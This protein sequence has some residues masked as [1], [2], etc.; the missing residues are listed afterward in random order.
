[1]TDY[2]PEDT[3]ALDEMARQVRDHLVADHMLRTATADELREI[4][5]SDRAAIR[6]VANLLLGFALALERVPDS[7]VAIVRH[8]RRAGA[9]L[10]EAA[11][12]GDAPGEGVDDEGVA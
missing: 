1:M 2:I 7:R 5:A 9:S 12:I 3:D 8:M 4:L 6:E 11:S 10:R